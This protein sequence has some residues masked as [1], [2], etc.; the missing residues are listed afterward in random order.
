[1][2]T[3]KM[4]VLAPTPTPMIR[5]ANVVNAVS[6][7]KVRPAYRRSRTSVSTRDRMPG[8]NHS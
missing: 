8:I 4:I 6:R 3:L 7:R 1:L 2:T 5:I